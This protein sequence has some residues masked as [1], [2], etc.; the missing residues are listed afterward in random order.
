MVKYPIKAIDGKVRNLPRWVF[1]LQ[2]ALGP[3]LHLFQDGDERAPALRQP[4]L[5]ARWNL[6]VVDTLDEAVVG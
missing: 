2:F 1:I 6:S 4:V 3:S 5:D